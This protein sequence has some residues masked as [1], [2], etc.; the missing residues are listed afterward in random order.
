MPALPIDGQTNWGDPLNAFIASLQAEAN[1]TQGNLNNH[2]ANTPSDPHG[3]RAY[4]Q[5]IVNPIING[6]NLP[7]GFVQLNSQGLIPSSLISGGGGNNV[8]GGAY[9][10]IFDAVATFGA[11]PNNG[12]DQSVRIQNALNA[13]GSAGGG[14]VWIGPG[15]FSMANYVVIPNNTWLMMSEGT[16]LSRIP[17][18]PNARYLITNV[19]FG[20]SNTPSSDIRI[21][22]GSLDAVGA[23][24]MTSQCTPIFLIQSVKN[25]IQDVYINNVFNAG[26]AI[27]I[28][29]CTDT[30]IDSCRFDGTGTNNIFFG[31]STFPAVRINSSNSGTTPNGLANTFYNNTISTN[32]RLTNSTTL[33]TSFSSG[34]YGALI[35]SDLTSSF[36]AKNVFIYGNATLYS[37]SLG[38]AVESNGQWS[39]T[40]NANNLFT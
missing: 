15:V 4:A 7:N 5:S 3:D 24:G 25:R 28:N 17:G 23:G 19:Q 21:T 26:P 30:I 1:S 36:H 39:G 37:S 22:G 35:A 18:S 16:I 20:T 12:S 31:G 6:V 14:Q 8:T 27:E 2:S 40:V 9:N 33:T 11:V 29:G 13:A 34:C 10:S 32:T 38:N